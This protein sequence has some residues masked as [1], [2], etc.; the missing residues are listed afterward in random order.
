MNRLEDRWRLNGSSC[1]G[2]GFEPRTHFAGKR[3]VFGARVRAISHQGAAFALA[4]I[5]C[6]SLAC[7]EAPDRALLIEIPRSEISH[8][9]TSIQDHV[10]QARVAWERGREN[11]ALSSKSLAQLAGEYGR[12]AHVYELWPTAEAAYRNALSLREDDFELNYLF[13]SLLATRGQPEEAL[14]RLSRVRD[15]RPDF[16]P[17]RV[18]VIEALLDLGN[19]ET[20]RAEAES[21]M[22]IAP[23]EPVFAFQLGQVLLSLGEW[24]EAINAYE[25]TL[26][27]APETSAAHRGLATAHAARGD[28]ERARHHQSLEGGSLPGIR[29]DLRGAL[30]RESRNTLRYERRAQEALRRG[31]ARAAAALLL[32][33]Q[34]LAPTQLRLN[35][36]LS[37]ALI[38]SGQPRRAA[39]LLEQ[40]LKEDIGD[41]A[42]AVG[43]VNLGQSKVRLGLEEEAIRHYRDALEIS[44]AV[45]NGS[46]NL[47]TL[48]CRRGDR[49]SSLELL[50]HAY[51]TSPS[52]RAALHLAACRLRVEGRSSALTTVRAAL[53]DRQLAP[54]DQGILRLA[55]LRIELAHREVSPAT[56]QAALTQ[57]ETWF[58]RTRRIEF[59]EMGIHALAFLG[60]REEALR[61]TRLALQAVTGAGRRD[62]QE[63]LEETQRRIV[64]GLAPIAVDPLQD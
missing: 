22:A 44:P 20:A 10:E 59:L 33:A 11:N 48:L 24:Q 19:L 37:A 40:F 46:L 14:E 6:G 42:R 28:M 12:A 39:A 38:E 47:G 56:A 16:L 64:D 26:E 15:L 35:I 30:D 21:G 36:S 18:A 55:E 32:H 5:L 49:Q 9:E 62:L 31:N 3:E 63:R 25:R 53:A 23:N 41:G 7:H 52:G 50:E 58:Q 2:P 8:L 54:T 1:C 60:E 29:D 57:A 45:P 61:N 43:L 51:S 4:L 27:I 34:E 13:A 17:L